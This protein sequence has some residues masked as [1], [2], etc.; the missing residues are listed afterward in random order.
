MERAWD[1]SWLRRT[2]TALERLL[3]DSRLNADW[4]PPEA[5]R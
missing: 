2:M 4:G 3:P 1:D 5:V